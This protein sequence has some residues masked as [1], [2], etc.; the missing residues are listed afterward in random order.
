MGCGSHFPP[1]FFFAP[2]FLQE[3]FFARPHLTLPE[4]P[5]P[6]FRIFLSRAFVNPLP[7][8]VRPRA[9][10]TLGKNKIIAHFPSPLF[11]YRKLS[12]PPLLCVFFLTMRLLREPD[13]Q[14]TVSI[15]PPLFP[16]P[17]WSLIVFRVTGVRNR[18]RFSVKAVHFFLFGSSYRPPALCR[19]FF[20]ILFFHTC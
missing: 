2:P 18:G 12:A 5:F 8:V 6:L 13:P 20:F 3:S 10:S 7:L 15:P 1:T 14:F 4:R 17:S 16:R 9:P 11:P 19:P